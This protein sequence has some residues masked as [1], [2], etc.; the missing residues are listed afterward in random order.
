M[1]SENSIKE[2]EKNIEKLG[3]EL[4]AIQYNFKI[5]NESS[6]KY[7]VRKIQG[8]GNYHKKTIEYFTQV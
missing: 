5:K 1:D 7:W 4:S 6:E 3:T 2:Y 8:F